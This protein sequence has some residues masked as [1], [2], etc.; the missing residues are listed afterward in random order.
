METIL[1][2]FISA[3]IV[4]HICLPMLSKFF[5]IYQEE[6][7][8]PNA[9]IILTTEDDIKRLV[10]NLNCLEMDEEFDEDEFKRLPYYEQQLFNIWCYEEVKTTSLRKMMDMNIRRHQLEMVERYN[11]EEYWKIKG[12]PSQS[13]LFEKSRKRR[14]SI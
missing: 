4:R 8:N 1:N 12:V 10:F 9:R 13:G 6:Y 3:D 14:T 2:E 7:R 5:V 11:H